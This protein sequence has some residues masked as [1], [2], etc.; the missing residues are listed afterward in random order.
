MAV[1]AACALS[2]C[3]IAVAVK[4]VKSPT[5]DEPWLWPGPP[6]GDEP[7]PYAILPEPNP[8]RYIPF[9]EFCLRVLKLGL[10]PGQ[11]ALAK[12]CFDPPDPEYPW[13][14][15]HE[16]YAAL[17]FGGADFKNFSPDVR[18]RVVLRCGRNGGKSTLAAAY[19]LYRMLT[20]DCSA[21]GP[22]DEPTFIIVAPVMDLAKITLKMAKE[23]ASKCDAIE[24]LMT[25]PL[26][27]SFEIR[28][29]DGVTVHC[30]MIAKSAGGAG[31]R[32]RAI[33]GLIVDES[34]FMPSND[35]GAMTDRQIVDGIEPRLLLDGVVI[36][37]STPYPGPSLT[38]EEYQRN[39]GHSKTAIVCKAPT[40]L[41]RDTPQNRARYESMRAHRP[42]NAAREFDC[43]DVDASGCYF[44]ASSIDQARAKSDVELTGGRTSCGVDLAFLSDGCAQVIVERRSGADGGQSLAVTLVDIFL[45]RPGLPLSPSSVLGV[46]STHALDQS[47]RVLAG[48]SHYIA[49]LRDEAQRWGLQ[50]MTGP[51]GPQKIAESFQDLR[52]LLDERRITLPPVGDPDGDALADQLKSVLFAHEPGGLEKPILPRIAGEGHCDLVSALVLAVYNDQSHFGKLRRPGQGAPIAWVRRG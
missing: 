14:P 2:A 52:V 21:L 51:V 15:E 23:M 13:M 31:G 48:D 49:S 20:A 18:S 6:H 45:P 24:R 8:R 12:A 47:V 22:G 17:F 38:K 9:T 37:A 34:E 41:L 32:G 16:V 44:R 40:L 46:F 35:A 10:T 19:I 30:K 11:Y 43:E 25:R 42:T 26:L 36:L 28:R 39:F 7:E 33:L 50:V 1:V 5:D 27:E 4:L 3:G 29:P